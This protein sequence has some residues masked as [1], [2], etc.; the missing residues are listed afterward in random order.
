M[1]KFVIINRAYIKDIYDNVDKEIMINHST[2]G[3]ETDRLNALLL[4]MK[5]KGQSRV[6]AIPLSHAISTSR[7]HDL[8][9]FSTDMV[10]VVNKTTSGL[11]F[12][13]CLP[14]NR[15]LYRIARA[16][17]G[18]FQRLA[19]VINN[20]ESKIVKSFETYLREYESKKK[21]DHKFNCCTDIDVIIEYMD[22]NYKNLPPNPQN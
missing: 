8:T 13:K 9:Y 17:Y 18:R 3:K 2:N 5:Y 10:D 11:Y 14:V 22:K 1:I 21:T 19:V 6:F 7:N 20:L 4:R 16:S 15:N 12:K